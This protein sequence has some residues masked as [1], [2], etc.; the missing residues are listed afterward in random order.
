MAELVAVFDAQK[1][2]HQAD[3]DT[4]SWETWDSAVLNRNLAALRHAAQECPA[5]IMAAIR[6]SKV[7]VPAVTDFN[8]TKAMQ[9]I[10]DDVNDA[11]AD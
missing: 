3:T 5:C 9:A 11:R 10:W 2:F 6:Q 7:P 4:T 8:F 1:A